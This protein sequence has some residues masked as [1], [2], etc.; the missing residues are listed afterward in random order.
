[1]FVS[2]NQFFVCIQSSS[3]SSSGDDVMTVDAVLQRLALTD[4]VDKFHTE[5]IDLDALVSIVW[6]FFSCL[7]VSLPLN[8][9]ITCSFLYWTKFL[10]CLMFLVPSVVCCCF[11]LLRASSRCFCKLV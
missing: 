6:R 4:Y 9:Y 8:F 10:R 3:A 11:V 5:Q 1:M 2:L 7:V